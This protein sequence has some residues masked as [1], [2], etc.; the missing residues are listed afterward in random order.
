MC[1]FNVYYLKNTLL[2]LVIS[3]ISCTNVHT[4]SKYQKTP[5]DTEKKI[6]TGAQQIERIENILSHKSIGLVANQTSILY[7]K[8]KHKVHLLDTLVKTNIKVNKIFSLEHGFRGTHDY[9]AHVNNEIDPQTGL[10]IIS[11][12]GKNKK[13]NTTDLSDIDYIV[14]DIQ[15]VGARFYTYISSL[16]YIMEACAESNIPLVILDRP[17]PNGHY[18]DGPILETK[19]KS[20]VGMHPIPVV[21]GMT[22]AEYAT[23][24]NGEQWLHNG[25]QCELHIIDMKHYN[26]NKSYSLP[27]KPSPNLP[28]DTA[29]NL[30]PSLCF[31]EG[32]TYSVGRGTQLQ[33]QIYGHP[34]YPKTN[35]YQ[36]TPI[37]SQGAKHPKHENQLCY[38]QNLTNT[39]KLTSIE[40]DFLIDAYK[41]SSNKTLFFNSFFTKLAGNTMLQKQIEAGLSANEIRES[42]STALDS[43]KE[44]REKYLL[45]P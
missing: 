44:T 45:Y 41:N 39:S 2:I 34:N 28:N 6:I 25:I 16:H 40:L 26:H 37:S 13:P 1:K 4:H 14:F 10:P 36:F 33:F 29:I 24:I 38:G 32:T 8:D 23:M 20:F 5:P 31:F 17:N 21:H 30:Y 19:H 7:N 35:H 22:V 3:F 42:W 43:F 9:G 18:I 27:V 15:D 11:I 12:Y